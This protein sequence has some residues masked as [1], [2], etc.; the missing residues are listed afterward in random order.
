MWNLIC[1]ESAATVKVLCCFFLIVKRTTAIS[2]KRKQ[3]PMSPQRRAWGG[4]RPARLSQILNKRKLILTFGTMKGGGFPKLS[5]RCRNS[6]R[7]TDKDDL[8]REGKPARNM[9][10]RRNWHHVCPD[11][12]GRCDLIYNHGKDDFILKHALEQKRLQSA[13]TGIC[14][15]CFSK[16]S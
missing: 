7:R 1:G 9:A 5:P 14:P 3:C 6:S 13:E 10:W 11:L 15:K 16:R 8:L 12:A 2:R 4:I